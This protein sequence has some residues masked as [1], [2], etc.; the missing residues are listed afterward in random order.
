MPERPRRARLL[1]ELDAKLRTVI[2][3]A[4]VF[5]HQVAD[6]VGLNATDAQCLNLLQLHGPL[7]AGRLARLTGLTTGAV[8][9]ALDRL[10]R[11][12]YVTR[13]RTPEDRRKVIATPV[14]RKI[15]RDILPL[16]EPQGRRMAAIYEGFR[17]DE[18][19]LILRYLSAMADVTV[20]GEPRERGGA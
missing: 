9:G 11:A 20:T 16:Y 10:E 1:E 5:N 14:Q 7:P 13:E 12:G 2:A 19:E 15:E 8:T 6:R 17:N 4:V 18:L 3:D